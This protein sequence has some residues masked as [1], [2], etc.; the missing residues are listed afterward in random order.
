M[1]ILNVSGSGCARMIKEGLAVQDLGHEVINLSNGWGDYSYYPMMHIMSYWSGVDGLAK[2]LKMFQSVDLVHVHSEPKYLGRIV[3][4]VLPDAKIIFDVHDSELFVKGDHIQ[5]EIDSYESADAFI[6][7]CKAYAEKLADD[8]PYEIIYNKAH[9]L[10]AQLAPMPRIGGVVYEGGLSK[11]G[12]MEH[13]NYVELASWF[14]DSGIPFH[15]YSAHNSLK[16]Y[17]QTGA[18]IY[19]AK[20]IFELCQM[21]TRYDWGLAA[22]PNDL[23]IH[24]QW[25]AAVP[26]KMF[27]YAASGLPVITWGKTEM[28]EIVRETNCGLVVD[29]REDLLNFYKEH[30][31]IR[32]SL[33]NRREE[34]TMITEGK[35]LVEFYQRV[36]N[37]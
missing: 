35:K 30:E 1:R 32:K 26:H 12:G 24:P 31:A 21:L 11:D 5:F 25:S 6:Y 3:R 16:G 29:R 17:E 9:P 34:F 27:D 37:G 13:R 18:L 14:T 7:P 15:I 28:A 19:G 8:R 4:E 10:A 23:E 2:K 36:L 22:S 33:E 20:R